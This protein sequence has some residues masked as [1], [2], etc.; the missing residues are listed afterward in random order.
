MV[1]VYVPSC[2]EQYVRYRQNGSPTKDV[3]QLSRL[4]RAEHGP[5]LAHVSF[6]KE[7]S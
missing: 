7:G 5:P 3:T 2:G 4:R 6:R 1:E